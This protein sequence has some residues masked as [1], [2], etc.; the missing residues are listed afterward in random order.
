MLEQAADV[1][2]G[3]LADL[4]V[5]LLVPEQVRLALPEALVAV[6]ARAVVTEN[7][8]GHEGHDLPMLA[9][10]VADDVLV[11][12]EAVCQLG[13]RAEPHVDLGL[14]GR[15]D[16]VM[17]DLDRHADLFQGQDLLGAQILE[18]VGRR[19]GEVTFLVPQLV[20]QVGALL[21]S[22]IPDALDGVNEVMRSLG[23]LVVAHII[24]NVELGLR[25]PVADIRDAGALQVVLGLLGDVPGV[26]G[27]PL[28]R[29]G[30]PHATDHAQRGYLE[31]RVDESCLR[32]REEQHV[33]FLDLLITPD[34]RP[35]EPESISEH[36]I[37][38]FSRWEREM[39]PDPG[40]IDEPKVD[41][42]D[43]GIFREFFHVFGM[44]SLPR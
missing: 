42:L 10:D 21:T 8:L 36:I 24:K 16:L 39:L 3:R 29:H 12:H 9:R 38:D 6:H 15:T 20:A 30:I 13:Q 18:L 26:A 34:A 27:V 41:D 44:L 40:K 11:I 33:A 1:V 2:A 4:A 32:I 25:T 43:I 14:T 19:A 37:R 17:M 31:D 7:R 28:P 23:R 35:I 22:R 5:A